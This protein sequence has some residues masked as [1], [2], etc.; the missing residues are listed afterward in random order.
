MNAFA[1]VMCVVSF[2][3]CASGINCWIGVAAPCSAVGAFFA[4]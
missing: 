3:A 4:R 2:S 1:S